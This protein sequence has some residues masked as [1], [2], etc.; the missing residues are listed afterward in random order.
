MWDHEGMARSRHRNTHAFALTTVRARFGRLFTLAA[1]VAVLLQAFVVQTHIDGLA[2]LTSGAAIE[3]SVGGGQPPAAQ[4]TNI[5]HDTQAPCPICQDLAT[6]GVTILSAAPALT[7][8]VAIIG[9]E[10]RI[11]IRRIVVRPGH[12]WQS[13]GPPPSL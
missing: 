10:A 7:T 3:R 12:A 9:H 13:R 8:M 2:L 5:V 1:M 6:A 4:L 11:D